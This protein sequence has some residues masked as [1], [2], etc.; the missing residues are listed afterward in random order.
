MVPQSVNGNRNFETVYVISK[1]FSQFAI[2]FE[3]TE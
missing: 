1:M 2:I 3:N